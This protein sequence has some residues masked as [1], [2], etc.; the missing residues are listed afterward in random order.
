[1]LFPDMLTDLISIDPAFA[2]KWQVC[3]SKEIRKGGRPRPR[4]QPEPGD[5]RPTRRVIHS[6]HYGRAGGLRWL[7]QP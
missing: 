6:G 2:G 1:M 3:T 7:G 4:S 5:I